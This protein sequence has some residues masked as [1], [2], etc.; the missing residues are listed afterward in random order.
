MERMQIVT[1]LIRV[2]IP[3]VIIDRS[4]WVKYLVIPEWHTK[5]IDREFV[6]SLVS[7]EFG[8]LLTKHVHDYV[9]ENIE[10]P[11]E[12]ASVIMNLA[13]DYLS[14]REI[15]IKSGDYI[16]LQNNLRKSKRQTK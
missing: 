8:E 12:I 4:D 9:Y 16:Q 6:D 15:V 3:R 14:G 1:K 7:K 13:D 2:Q 11:A 10:P 5:V